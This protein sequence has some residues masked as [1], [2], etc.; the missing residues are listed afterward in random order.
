MRA[1]TESAR[2]LIRIY[3]C[4]YIP[5]SQ[6]LD[7]VEGLHLVPMT[8]VGSTRT[9]RG[10]GRKGGKRSRRM[11][12]GEYST[13]RDSDS[14]NSDEEEG[15]DDK[16]DYDDVDDEEDDDDEEE[17][18]E[19][20]LITGLA[21]MKLLDKTRLFD[22]LEKKRE[23]GKKRKGKGTGRG[24]TRKSS[25]TR[26][27][28]HSTDS[29]K[30]THDVSSLVHSPKRSITVASSLSP[31]STQAQQLSQAAGGRADA[32]AA[33]KTSGRLPVSEALLKHRVSNTPVFPAGG[34]H[35][36]RGPAYALEDDKEEDDD[37]VCYRDVHMYI[38]IYIYIYTLWVYVYIHAY[39]LTFLH[40]CIH[41]SIR[42]S[43]STSTRTSIRRSISSLYADDSCGDG[44]GAVA[45]Q[46]CEEASSVRV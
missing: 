10:E 1:D 16:V 23:F 19:D 42:A 15:D 12:R 41:T 28:N 14:D 36:G 39:I 20:S 6:L 27:A 33:S 24:G 2:I 8:T 44:D 5:R 4:A 21:E 26:S 38:S 40:P 9:P 34:E 25:H 45:R 32:A 13:M 11:H 3:F 35:A 46:T 18:E 17:E 29:T 31:Q 43:T 7:D 22:E 37:E 30:S